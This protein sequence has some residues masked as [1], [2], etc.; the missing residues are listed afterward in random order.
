MGWGHCPK[1]DSLQGVARACRHVVDAVSASAPWFD[2]EFREFRDEG[3]PEGERVLGAFFC[4]A[5]IDRSSL[6]PSGS[7]ALWAVV[8]AAGGEVE[9]VCGGCL[10]RWLGMPGHSEQNAADAA[11]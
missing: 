1:C 2:A 11:T 10:R 8:D 6:P 7:P 3:S 9:G 5:C 4:R